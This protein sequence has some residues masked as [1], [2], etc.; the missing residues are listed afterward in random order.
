MAQ[1]LFISDEMKATISETFL[2][3]MNSYAQTAVSQANSID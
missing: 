1:A 3:D 2:K